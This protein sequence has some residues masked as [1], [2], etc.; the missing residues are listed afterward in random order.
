MTNLATERLTKLD[1]DL[2]GLFY[3]CSLTDIYIY[4]YIF[5]TDSAITFIIEIQARYI[6]VIRS[7]NE[8]AR[9]AASVVRNKLNLRTVRI[10]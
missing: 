2:S 9:Q 3:Q 10:Q 4:I 1:L 5:I 6:A 7:T 8:T